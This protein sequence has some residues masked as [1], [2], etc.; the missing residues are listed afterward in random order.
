MVALSR[1]EREPP[2]LAIVS[3]WVLGYQP[4]AL[5]VNGT[6][7]AVRLVQCWQGSHFGPI[8]LAS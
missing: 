1:A 2:L 3:G 8:T 7:V 4:W 6:E 5:T